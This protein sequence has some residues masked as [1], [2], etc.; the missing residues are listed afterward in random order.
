VINQHLSYTS[1]A[2]IL[3]RLLT[4]GGVKPGWIG[5]WSCLILIVCFLLFEY[6]FDRYSLFAI[7]E[8][9]DETI[10][11]FRIAIIHI[12]LVCYLPT[13]Y[14]LVILRSLKTMDVLAPRLEFSKQQFTDLISRVGNYSW[15]TLIIGCIGA[16]LLF[17][18]VT[19]VTTPEPNPWSVYVMTKEVW[20]HRI[21][22]PVMATFIFT[23]VYAIVIESKRLSQ[24]A[25]NFGE[26]DLVHLEFTRV[27][28]QNALAN[29][30]LILGWAAITSLFLMEK[31]FGSI[32]VTGWIT[33]ITIVLAAFLGPVLGIRRQIVKAKQKELGWCDD[34]IERARDQFKN[35]EIPTSDSPPQFGELIVY[36]QYV[37]NL[38][39][40]PFDVSTLL[41]L[42]LYSLIPLGSWLGGA[43]VERTVDTFLG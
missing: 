34:N 4:T 28:G 21:L 22:T 42:L 19:F 40:W 41:R 8:Y 38:S 20:W 32:I 3:V 10:R 23:F 30:L 37:D 18:Y 16:N 33:S 43:M 5:L 26:L 6:M 35:N 31:G 7:P 36:R 14:V 24:L 29:S 2:S 12:L 39:E 9:K 11:N 13:A 25:N 27:F 1:H 17:I 15:Q